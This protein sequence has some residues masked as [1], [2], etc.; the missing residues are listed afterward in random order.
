[1]VGVKRQV[2]RE[3]GGDAS[4]P[5]ARVLAA[6]FQGAERW[7][8]VWQKIRGSEPV[9]ITGALDPVEDAPVT[10]D[11]RQGIEAFRL[12]QTTLDEIW[13]LVLPPGTLLELRKLAHAP[14]ESFRMDDAVWA[15]SIFDFSLAWRQHTLNREHVLA[16]F[17]PLFAA[18][19][20]SIVMEMREADTARF[21]ERLER[22]CL[23]FESEKPYLISRWRWPDRFSP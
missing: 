11:V 5:L 13:K 20:S 14:D 8:V 3:Q 10:V 19:V 2:W 18:W 16:G 21:E 1:M 17:A 4:A 7:Q 22:M 12:A 15:R 23:R 6:L 9:P